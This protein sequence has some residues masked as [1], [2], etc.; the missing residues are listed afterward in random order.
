MGQTKGARLE[1][2][3]GPARLEQQLAVTPFPIRTVMSEPEPEDSKPKLNLIISHSGTRTSFPVCYC[4]RCEPVLRTCVCG[5]SNPMPIH[6]RLRAEV[7]V[8]V[9]ANMQFKKIFEVA[10]VRAPLSA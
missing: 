10:E 4:R 7:T 1:S 3:S 9:K 8:K 6:V 5:V 2:C